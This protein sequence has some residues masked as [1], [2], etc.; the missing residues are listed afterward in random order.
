MRGKHQAIRKKKY[1]IISFLVVTI[2]VAGVSYVLL[3]R[4]DNNQEPV[5]D[6]NKISG[7]IASVGDEIVRLRTD[8]NEEYI[9][10]TPKV[11]IDGNTYI[12]NNIIVAY[13]GQLDIKNKDIQNIDVVSIDI[14]TTN[15][16]NLSEDNKEGMEINKDISDL[17]GTMSLEEKVGQMFM[18]RC[19]DS[20]PEEFVDEYQPGG[21]ILFG[22]DFK[23]KTETEVKDNI[24]SYQNK[25][26]IP[27]LIGTDEEGGTV[28]RVKYIY[29]G[30]FKSPQRIYNNSGFDAIKEDTVTKSKYLKSLG[31]N[32]NFAPVCDVSTDNKDFIYNRSFG[33]D[34]TQTSEYISTVVNEMNNQKM[35][36]VLKH[37]PG[38]GNNIDN[39]KEV[40]RDSR[41][42]SEFESSDFLPFKE[43]IK[44]GANCILVT[45]NIM[46]AVDGDNPASLSNKVHEMLRNEFNYY[47]VIMSDDLLTDSVRKLDSDE[48]IAI[49]AIQAG[50][51]MLISNSADTQIKTIIE[52]VESGVISRNQIDNSVARI[53]MWKYSLGLIPIS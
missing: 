32:L 16:I 53:L 1:L 26:S 5:I 19:P 38:Y 12:G 13:T 48:N 8:K 11:N 35:G 17:L 39:S 37:F 14:Q 45:H 9:I 15:V 43:G 28:S 30:D 27:M 40:V 51:D 21:Y 22:Q 44:E 3:N 10:P 31:I 4:K 49:R 18:V 52:A 36:S 42:L 23:N 41:D 6:A 25:S 29:N 50:N 33:K 20:N 34:A 2:I 47:G 46:E 7:Q 24:S